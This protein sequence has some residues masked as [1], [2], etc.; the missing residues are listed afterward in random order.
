MRVRSGSTASSILLSPSTSYQPMATPGAS[1]PN[2][3]LG[4]DRSG[5]GASSLRPAS[6]VTNSSGGSR[7]S[8]A[9][10]APSAISRVSSGASVRW[11]EDALQTVKERRRQERKER[12]EQ[13][14]KEGKTRRDSK[15]SRNPKR[16]SLADIFPET[17]SAPSRPVSTT[18]TEVAHEGLP[19]L[20]LETATC[21]GHSVYSRSSASTT[22]PVKKQ[23]PRPWS[24][25]MLPKDMS[26]P[27]GIREDGEGMR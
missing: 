12:K 16:T 14:A 15:E 18:S 22:T 9:S 25:Q 7:L 13:D 4:R 26:R 19:I 3:P 23:R 2:N 24:D 5:S 8:T 11:D 21:D 17:V 10:C 20:T 1:F 27:T 6:T